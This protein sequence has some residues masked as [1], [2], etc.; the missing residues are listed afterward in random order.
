MACLQTDE[1]VPWC[2]PKLGAQLRQLLKATVAVLDTLLPR[3]HP[4]LIQHDQIMLLASPF[5]SRK[6]TRFF[7]AVKPYLNA[8]ALATTRLMVDRQGAN[9]YTCRRASAHSHAGT[10]RLLL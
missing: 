9:A 2:D 6:R 1:A 4:F 10:Y 8:F 5:S 3:A 7:P